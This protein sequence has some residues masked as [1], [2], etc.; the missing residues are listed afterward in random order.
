MSNVSGVQN[1]RVSV[2]EKYNFEPV[3]GRWPLASI[4]RV[5]AFGL[6]TKTETKILLSRRDWL[7]D[8]GFKEQCVRTLSVK[9]QQ[10]AGEG[11]RDQNPND[12]DAVKHV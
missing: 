10:R 3:E 4:D 6:K 1:T 8:S 7:R 11:S 9:R 5:H 2:I 12:P